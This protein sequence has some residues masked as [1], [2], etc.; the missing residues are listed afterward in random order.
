MIFTLIFVALGQRMVDLNDQRRS[1]L[2]GNIQQR[3]YDEVEIAR[4]VE[5]GYKR[6]FTIPRTIMGE[7]YTISVDDYGM[8]T[9]NYYNKSY[10]KALPQPMMGGFCF[11]PTE[12]KYDYY[13]L[14]VTKDAGVVS[15]SS[16]FNC[17]YS[18]A[19]CKNAEK[20]GWCDWLSRPEL[21]PGFNSSCCSGHCL[22][23]T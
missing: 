2:V 14:T 10:F 12:Q 18:Y 15:L 1:D 7:D 5:D 8:L 4:S 22:C 9:I 13:D 19:V 16:C 20:N 17:S 3:V 23:C 11:S 21:F 6:G